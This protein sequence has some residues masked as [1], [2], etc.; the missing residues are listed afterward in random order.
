MTFIFDKKIDEEWGGAYWLKYGVHGI[1][2]RTCVIESMTMIGF[3]MP[4]PITSVT[5]WKHPLRRFFSKIGKSTDGI[6]ACSSRR[7]RIMD[8]TYFRHSSFS[9]RMTHSV[10][11]FWTIGSILDVVFC[12]NGNLVAEQRPYTWEDSDQ[13]RIW[14]A[15]I[16]AHKDLYLPP[17]KYYR[18]YQNQR[19]KPICHNTNGSYWYELCIRSR[20]E[21]V[22]T[23]RLVPSWE[24]M[25]QICS[26][27]QSI[28]QSSGRYRMPNRWAVLGFN[29]NGGTRWE[30]LDWLFAIDLWTAYGRRE[31]NGLQQNLNW[32]WMYVNVVSM[33]VIPITI[34]MV[35]SVHWI[36]GRGN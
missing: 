3:C 14:Y 19:S 20:D 9:S 6:P 11:Q 25:D 17:S 22:L 24:V 36:L 13:P 29:V 21:C 31:P 27:Y 8:C 18:Y 2:Y 7:M 34:T 10:K 12:P 33:G 5:I 28:R 30:V 35:H 23:K 32:V 4:T 1:V 16:Q 26:K 15:L